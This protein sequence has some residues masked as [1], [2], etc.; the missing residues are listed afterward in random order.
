MTEIKDI[1]AITGKIKRIHIESIH[2][3]EP[4]VDLAARFSQLPGTV[5][6]LSGGNLDC[7]RYHIIAANPF[8]TYSGKNQRMTIIAENQTFQF[9]GDPFDVL[10]SLIASY[11]LENT[12]LPLPIASGLFGYLSYDLKGAIEELP[13]TA[14]DDLGLPHIYFIIPSL[15]LVHDKKT[16][17]TKLYIPERDTLT[18]ATVEKCIHLYRKIIAQA[19]S[20]D[21]KYKGTGP[22]FHSNFTKESYMDTIRIIREY[23]ASGHVYQVNMS[24]RF[25]IGFQGNPFS[26]FQDLYRKNPAP[27]FAFINAGDHQIVSTSP[28][29]FLLQNGEFIESRPIKGT[30]PRGKTDEEDHQLKSELVESKKDDAELSMIVDLIRNDMGKV[31]QP[32]TVNVSDHKRLE[33]YQNV[34]HLVSVIEGKLDDK[35]DSID[36]LKATFPGGSI[37]GCPKIRSMEIIDELETVRRHIYTGSIG[38]ISF[39]QTMD[40]SIA[41]R[42]A[43][44]INDKLFFSV[45]GGIVYDSDPFSEYSETLHKGQTLIDTITGHQDKEKLK[46]VH[47]WF[48]GALI[49]V[50]NIRIPITDLGFQYGYG[51]FETIRVVNGNIRFLGEH[52]HR[53]NR[54]WAELYPSDPPDLSW[55]EIILQV[56]RKN[57]LMDQVAAIKLITSFGNRHHKPFNHHLVVTSRP[58]THRLE[59]TGQRGLTIST[60]PHS[61]KTPLADHKSLNYLFYLQAGAYAKQNNADEA[62]ILNPDNSISETHTANIFLISGKHVTLPLSEHVLPGVMEKEVV[63]LLRSWNYMIERK[64]IYKDDLFLADQVIASNSLMGAVAVTHIDGAPLQSTRTIS[65]KINL[66]IL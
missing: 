23:I 66:V 42:T 63:K 46:P 14:I 41:I 25:E 45:G 47:A 31:C 50:Q 4:W 16:A 38:Y 49:P 1:I 30:R 57:G 65:D 32:E 44:I 15:L 60:Y 3:D 62:L 51:F 36:L 54:T 12:N 35:S 22:G 11:S 48:N 2:L 19:P 33:A 8:L 29:R 10:R 40:L 58:Y 39:H 37:T 34:Y 24:Q 13:R 61:R 55:D 56:I 6:L 27:F 26:L 7:A 9:D 59:E 17:Q 21:I 28:E 64:K 18:G 52:I 20:E 43:T 5:V 53:F